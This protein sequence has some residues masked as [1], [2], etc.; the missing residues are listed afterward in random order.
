MTEMPP[1][2]NPIPPPPGDWKSRLKEFARGIWEKSSRKWNESE[3]P[4]KLSHG[5]EQRLLKPLREKSTEWKLREKLTRVLPSD[6]AKT[7]PRTFE[8]LAVAEW[9]GTAVQRQGAGFYGTAITI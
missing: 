4:G 5:F 2:E 3:L 1:S 7:L 9:V 6:L 8:P